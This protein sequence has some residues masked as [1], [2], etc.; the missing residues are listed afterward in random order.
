MAEK[1]K[2]KSDLRKY[3]YKLERVGGLTK[4]RNRVMEEREGGREDEGSESRKEEGGAQKKGRRVGSKWKYGQRKL[5][6]ERRN[7]VRESKNV[8]Y[9][10]GET[11]RRTRNEGEVRKAK[12]GVWLDKIK[13]LTHH[14]VI[15]RRVHSS[16]NA[17]P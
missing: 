9:R 8:G 10:K 17:H 3:H 16:T 6:R 4:R 1:L 11:G 2:G 7:E 13:M 15:I 12:E 5:E 14:Y